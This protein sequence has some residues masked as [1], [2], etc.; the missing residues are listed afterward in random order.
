MI[1]RYLKGEIRMSKKSKQVRNSNNLNISGI[2][3]V[4]QVF[5]TLG[6]TN[7]KSTHSEIHK[8]FKKFSILKSKETTFT[9]SN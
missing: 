7:K 1:V 6:L 4:E 3:R 2:G 9:N 8:P 5:K